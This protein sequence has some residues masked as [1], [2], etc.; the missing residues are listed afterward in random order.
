MYC[1]NCGIEL[2][3]GAKFCANCGT[4]QDEIKVTVEQNVE[5]EALAVEPVA[6]T[7]A[8]AAPTVA[9]TQTISTDPPLLAGIKNIL[10]SKLFLV[11]AILFSVSVAMSFFAGMIGTPTSPS[12]VISAL[13]EIEIP[14]ELEELIPMDQIIEYFKSQEGKDALDS[15]SSINISINIVPILT[16]VGLWLLFGSAKDS[17]NKTLNAGLKILKASQIISLVLSFVAAGVMLILGLCTPLIIELIPATDP[18]HEIA[19][20]VGIVV[21]C[22]IMFIAFAIVGVFYIVI[23]TAIG[24][25][26]KIVNGQVTLRGINFVMGYL[27]AIAGMTL[28]GA[29][30]SWQGI[31][32]QAPLVAVYVILG[33]LIIKFKSAVKPFVKPFYEQYMPAE[34]VE[35]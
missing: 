15:S 14:E 27:F 23:C 17:S 32:V 8:P 24:S 2:E 22:A 3:N 18:E 12:D 34:V 6:A 31:L 26:Q 4:E 7:V 33:I 20:T 25:A 5:P 19:L 13:E 16:L 11:A 30:A 9:Q 10:G 21:F 28:M 29:F 1:K 35:E